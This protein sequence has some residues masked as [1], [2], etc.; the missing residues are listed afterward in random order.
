MSSPPA[1]P[2][3]RPA[4]PIVIAIGL[5]GG[6]ISGL[7]GV[8]GGIVMVPLMVAIL[9]MTQ[10]RAHGTSL[11]MIVPIAISAMI[12]YLIAHGLQWQVVISLAG[13]SVGFA[14][15]GAR[16]TKHLNATALRRG[17]AVLLALTAVRLLLSAQSAAMF[18]E[19]EGLQLIV[20]ALI[21]GTFTGLVAG[22]MGVGGGIV[23]VPAM[24]IVMGIDQHVAQGISLAVIV[25]TAIS[26]AAQH[27]RQGNVDFRWAL[28]I[29]AGGIVGG[30]V[31]A[32]FAQFIP[33]FG[34][35]VLFAVF[36]IY[37]AQRMVGVQGWLVRRVRAARTPAS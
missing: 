23:M 2:V 37:S 33:A 10:H 18:G 35:R 29:A 24:V 32:Q 1:P 34:L 21:A 22:T 31:G 6:L 15:V 9:A 12:P 4:A 26:G 27:F 8:G 13:T 36:A 5:T 19:M 16:L 25:P 28:Y 30:A 7:V 20:A 17:F 11:A 3:R 14:V